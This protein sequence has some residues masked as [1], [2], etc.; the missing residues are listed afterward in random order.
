MHFRLQF[1]RFMF[2]Q[3][4]MALEAARLGIPPAEHFILKMMQPH[5]VK[6]YIFEHMH[7]NESIPDVIARIKSYST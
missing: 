1:K 7:D 5:E 3:W 2:Y 6:S 4:A